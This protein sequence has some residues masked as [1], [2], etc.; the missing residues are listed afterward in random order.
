MDLFE[1]R[2]KDTKMQL[3][4]LIKLDEE[5]SHHDNLGNNFTFTI[6]TKIFDSILG[7]I[8]SNYKKKLHPNIKKMI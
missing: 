1:A 5:R 3:H 8:E 6:V 7:N 4:F 2:M